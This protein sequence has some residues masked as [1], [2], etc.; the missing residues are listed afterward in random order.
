M[1]KAVLIILCFS[2]VILLCSCGYSKEEMQIARDNAY[3]LGYKTGY[4]EGHSE[5]YRDA[6]WDYYDSRYEEGYKEGYDEGAKSA[7][8]QALD[9]TG[10]M[11]AVYDEQDLYT[12][13]QALE[14][15]FD[16]MQE[17]D[18]AMRQYQ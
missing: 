17:A 16:L 12:P 5:G 11:W 13:E 8:W 6:E 2:V 15:M 14:K 18:K 1:K 10:R 4:D 9:Y 3:S 7:S